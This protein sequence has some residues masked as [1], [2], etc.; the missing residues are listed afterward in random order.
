MVAITATPFF[1]VLQFVL[2]HKLV[3]FTIVG[4]LLSANYYLMY[5]YIPSKECAPG[6]VCHV[7]S[8]SSRLGRKV[9]WAS[10]GVYTASLFVTYLLLPILVFFDR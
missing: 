9:L 4:V 8:P 2:D 6:E 7:D 1:P 10:V 3:A 5:S